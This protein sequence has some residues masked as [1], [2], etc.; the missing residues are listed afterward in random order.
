MIK[1][2][3]L[4]MNTKITLDNISKINRFVEVCG[5]IPCEVAIKQGNFRVNAKSLMGVLSLDLS[6]ELNVE[7]ENNRFA[8]KITTFK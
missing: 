8:D 7:V 5:A 3:N 1:E 2:K 6:Q 4:K